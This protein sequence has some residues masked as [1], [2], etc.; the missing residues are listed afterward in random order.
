LYSN[1]IHQE[2]AGM[3]DPTGENVK[4]NLRGGLSLTINQINRIHQNL[5]KLLENV[6]AKFALL[7]DTSG[8]LVTTSGDKGRIDSSI[9]GSL[10]AADL[11]ASQEIARLTGEFQDYQ[12][13]LR[14]GDRTHII[15][16]EA[17]K[18][19]A[20]LVIF[21][22]EVPIGWARRLIQNTA[23]EI[24]LLCEKMDAISPEEP[25]EAVPGNLPDLFTDALDQIWKD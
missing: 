14:E 21:S 24:G 18:N 7:V 13:I 5:S 25:E 3:S 20:F 17:G 22:R 1:L 11:A 6:P 16:S 12:M 10:I 2:L 9:L 19:L 23:R 8:Q 4:V 15:I